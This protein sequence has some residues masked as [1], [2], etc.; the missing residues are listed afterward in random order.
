MIQSLSFMVFA[1]LVTLPF[2]AFLFALWEAC[3]ARCVASGVAKAL[4]RLESRSSA[5]E[6][7]SNSN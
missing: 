6:E 7:S 5:L 4:L 1:P 3:V 2:E